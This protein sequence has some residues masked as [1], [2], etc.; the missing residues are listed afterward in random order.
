MKKVGTSQNSF[1]LCVPVKIA[2]SFG[3]K[4]QAICGLYYRKKSNIVN[5]LQD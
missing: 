3:F 2:E 1:S 4:Y 5:E